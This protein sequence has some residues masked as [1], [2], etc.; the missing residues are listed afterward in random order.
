ME[1]AYRLAGIALSLAL[2]TNEDLLYISLTASAGLS[3]ASTIFFMRSKN[4]GFWPLLN[5]RPLRLLRILVITSIGSLASVLLMVGLPAILSFNGGFMQEPESTELL[6][7]FGIFR[8]PVLL[9]INFLLGLFVAF[10]A[11]NR[12]VVQGVVKKATLLVATV[13][14]SLA[15]AVFFLHD[16]IMAIM[17]PTLLERHISAFIVSMLVLGA[18]SLGVFTLRVSSYLAAGRNITYTS[19][20]WVC[21]VAQVG[22]LL[23]TSDVEAI[24]LSLIMVPLLVLFGNNLISRFYRNS[25]TR[26]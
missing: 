15:V 26:N 1:A 12:E 6:S 9:P 16:S 22:A 18:G 10:A 20:W 4:I 2:F 21:C 25:T 23:A 7:V 8:A 3:L 11:E 17:F 24:A 14:A 5:A 13:A 19:L